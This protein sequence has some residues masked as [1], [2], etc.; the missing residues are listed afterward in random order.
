MY[1]SYTSVGVREI[2][3]VSANRSTSGGPGDERAVIVEQRRS[4]FLLLP[5][6]TTFEKPKLVPFLYHKPILLHTA[7]LPII[8]NPEFVSWVA[9]ICS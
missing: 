4:S 5:T 6:I 7:L 2:R 3:A 8:S 9:S 1:V